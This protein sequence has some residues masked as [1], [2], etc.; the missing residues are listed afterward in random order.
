M[1]PQQI[2]PRPRL[3]DGTVALAIDER[4]EALAAED[5]VERALEHTGHGVRAR[6]RDELQ[7]VLVLTWERM[8]GAGRGVRVPE[9]FDA[10]EGERE[11]GGA[12]ECGGGVVEGDDGV[13]WG[14]LDRVLAGRS[15]AG[16]CMR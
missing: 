14:G 11:R 13:M 9:G 7:H 1:Q 15:L 12:A 16:A 6:E 2:H 4:P 3:L 10:R 8:S 5:L